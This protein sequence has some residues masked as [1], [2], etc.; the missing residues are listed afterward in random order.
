M[1]NGTAS[2]N[3]TMLLEMM[4]D[5]YVHTPSTQAIL[6]PILSIFTILISVPAL[7]WHGTNR[8]LPATTLISW[9]VLGNIYNTVNA[10]LWPTDDISTWWLGY[11]WCDIEAKLDLAADL[12]MAG[13]V[14]CLLSSLAKALDTK[15]PLINQTPRQ[16]LRR[17]FEYTLCF[18]LPLYIAAAHYIIQPFRYYIFAISGCTASAN[19]NYLTI[20][21][22]FIWPPII[23]LLA[24]YHAIL[25]LIRLRRYRRDFGAILSSTSSGLNR[26]RFLRLFCLAIILLLIFLP[27]QIYVFYRNVILPKDPFNFALIHNPETWNQV[28]TVPT[29]GI[30]IFDRWIRIALGW[31]VFACLCLGADAKAMYRSWLIRLHLDAIFPSLSSRTGSATTATN[32][33][34]STSTSLGSKARLFI[35]AKLSNKSSSTS[36]SGSEAGLPAGGQTRAAV[37]AIRSHKFVTV[38]SST[39]SDTSDIIMPMGKILGN[40]AYVVTAPPLQLSFWAK[41]VGVFTGKGR[42]KYVPSGGDVEMGVLGV[43]AAREKKGEVKKSWSNAV[44]AMARV[45]EQKAYEA[46]LVDQLA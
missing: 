34:S 13:S 6:L 17:L 35:S 21:L 33:T 43:G 5:P 18:I 14:A 41:L 23:L 38:T 42:L 28:I 44:E 2:T 37:P 27:L 10:L 46:H 45:K 12:G 20:F 22:I 3:I 4:G 25:V 30:V 11:G 8:N 15:K 7:A 26:A 16:L 29:F 36:R 24:S 1:A 31:T 19:E 39:A 40:T 9:I 32:T